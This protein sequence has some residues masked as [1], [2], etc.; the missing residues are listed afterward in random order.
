[1]KIYCALMFPLIPSKQH[2]PVGFYTLKLLKIK[3]IFIVLAREHEIAS[4]DTQFICSSA[5]L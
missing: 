3:T 1:M 4:N 5:I 2:E